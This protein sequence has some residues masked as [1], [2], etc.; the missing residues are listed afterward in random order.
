MISDFKGNPATT[1]IV[2]YS[3]VEG[4][5]D[6]QEHYNSLSGAINGIPKHN[7]LMVIGDF[8]EHLGKGKAMYSYHYATNSNGQLIYALAAENNLAITNNSFR[9]K[10]GK[11]W[12]FTSDMSGTQSQVEYIL[13]NR[14]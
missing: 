8:N 7:V 6:A 3:P 13:I 1:I 9:K 14:K 12:S 11:L 10:K 5:P 4:S 2:H